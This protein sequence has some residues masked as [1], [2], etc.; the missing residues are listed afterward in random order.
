[1]QQGCC[2][3]II[4][5]AGS[6]MISQGTD[7]LSRGDA[8]EGVMTG[9]SMLEFVP[10]HRTCLARSPLLKPQ[11]QL[12]LQPYADMLGQKISFLSEMDWFW[13][14]HDLGQGN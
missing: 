8:N 11:I 3:N 4:H 5:I 6:R 13:K 14:G 1:M 12:C 2:V 7:G 9:R 10:L